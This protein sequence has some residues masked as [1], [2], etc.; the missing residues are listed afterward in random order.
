M[1]HTLSILL[2]CVNLHAYIPPVDALLEQ[3]FIDR[4]PAQSIE[5]LF[6]HEI[7]LGDTLTVLDE[8]WFWD[9][10]KSYFLWKGLSTPVK[11]VLE[12]ANYQLGSN[13][14]VS[15][16][17]FLFRQY[18]I[19][20]SPEGFRNQLLQEKFLRKEQLQQ[21][22]VDYKPTG[23]PKLWNTQER[24]IRQK[25]I[26]F[27]LLPQGLAITLIGTHQP[28][29]KRTLFFQ[30]M[31]PNMAISRIE[32]V[33]GDIAVSWNFGNFAPQGIVKGFYPKRA[34]FESNGRSVVR[35]ELVLLRPANA[36]AVAEIRALSPN[37]EVPSPGEEIFKW[38]LSYR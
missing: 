2:F 24:Y 38:L 14:S 25:E 1:K 11:G 10:G 33:D 16:R 17:S 3:V 19:S 30:P 13:L 4:K 8:Q 18:F 28:N 23:D 7:Q 36:R 31:G 27:D 29:Q 32:W 5:I 34:W 35:S 37:G 6:R 21:F 20:S 9:H 22:H 26:S 12:K 15:S